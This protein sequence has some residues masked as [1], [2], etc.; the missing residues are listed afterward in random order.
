MRKSVE[1]R[2]ESRELESCEAVVVSQKQLQRG[3]LGWGR[4]VFVSLFF[5]LA[6]VF[7]AIEGT[8]LYR[9]LW[10]EQTPFHGDQGAFLALAAN[11][12]E[13]RGFVS[14][15][16]SPFAPSVE[17]T[18][19]ECKRQPLYPAFLSLVAKRDVAFVLRAKTVTLIISLV[20]LAL[21]FVLP[22]I[23]WGYFSGAL[24]LFLVGVHNGFVRFS[25]MI[26]CENCLMLFLLLSWFFLCVASDRLTGTSRQTSSTSPKHT[27]L[28]FGI[29]GA[30]V[31]AAYLTK[32]S[33][34]MAG[35]SLAG[36]L[37]LL[38]VNGREITWRTRLKVFG[39]FLLGM[40]VFL[41]PSIL[42]NWVATG[43]AFPNEELKGV[44]WIDSGRDAWR[45][46][47]S[48]PN[49]GDYV[50][51]HGWKTMAAKW[52]F[53]LG[54]V[55]KRTFFYLRTHPGAIPVGW[56]LMPAFAWGLIKEKPPM[57]MFSILFI[58]LHFC[59]FAWYTHIDIAPRFLYP[60]VFFYLLYSSN[61]ARLL[62]ETFC[63]W[64]FAGGKLRS[65]TVAVLLVGSGVC[66]VSGL[67]DYDALHDYRRVPSAQEIEMLSAIKDIVG[68]DEILCMGPSHELAYYW[69]ID[70]RRIFVPS[71]T[72]LNEFT[73]YLVDYGA[74]Y[75]L[76]DSSVLARRRELLG[77][78]F[79]WDPELGISDTG[80]LK[81]L[82]PVYKSGGYPNRF[83]LYR[84]DRTVLNGSRNRPRDLQK[85]PNGQT[86]SSSGK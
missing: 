60:L 61:G 47:D 15:R 10:C 50:A 75:F 45:V 37:L 71:Y 9:L 86:I 53:G 69:I 6:A 81:W 79:T 73:D 82:V 18:H 54:V 17:I 55:L 62:V 32:K 27:L 25:M 70:R 39:S 30:F 76:I 20:L 16:L 8:V 67:L 36:A 42:N 68:S 31:G 59:F 1:F 65:V 22:S 58:V 80:L 56:L 23:R 7:I 46:Y 33:G 41:A 52:F 77:R 13:G 4:V 40:L 49:F 57:R 48:V 14:D 28:G 83:A 66:S 72:R 2:D 19:Q 3:G 21:A 34:S 78:F 24:F 35:M 74:A 51:R 5:A 43:S 29:A 12:A 38:S 11:M 84:I 64:R 44:M 26:F 85:R 63:R